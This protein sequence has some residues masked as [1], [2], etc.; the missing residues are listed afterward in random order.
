MKTFAY[1]L[2]PFLLQSCKELPN[3]NP[4]DDQFNVSTSALVQDQCDTI[5]AGCGFFNLIRKEGN[6][7]TYYQ[8]F[9]EDSKLIVAKGFSYSIDTFSIDT[10]YFNHNYDIIYDSLQALPIRVKEINSELI[11]YGYQIA[12]VNSESIQAVN[13]RTRDTVEI[14]KHIFIEK[15]TIKR[16]LHYF[17]SNP[18]VN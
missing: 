9:N 3:Y 7:R 2:I 10:L 15:G 14:N 18:K 11:R 6:L 4:F 5:S 12:N 16:S 13:S 1:L 17:K 8:I